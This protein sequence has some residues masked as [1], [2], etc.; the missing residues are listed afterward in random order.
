MSKLGSYFH[1]YVCKILRNNPLIDQ[2][3]DSILEDTDG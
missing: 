1:L 3:S 2:I